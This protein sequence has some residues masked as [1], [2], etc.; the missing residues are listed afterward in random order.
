MMTAATLE[1]MV[2]TRAKV[3]SSN[4]HSWMQHGAGL[5]GLHVEHKAQPAGLLRQD[6]ARVGAP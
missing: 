5:R 1:A 4:G 2:T 6:E 3:A